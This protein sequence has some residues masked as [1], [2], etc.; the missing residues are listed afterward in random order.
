MSEW[1]RIFDENRV[2]PPPNQTSRLAQGPSQAFRLVFK[3]L[4]GLHLN[5][6]EELRSER[7][8][9][10]VSLFDNSLHRFF[11]RTWKSKPHQA[12]KR[13]QEQPCKV[14]FN[15]VVYFHTS[16]CL[17]SVVA[18]VEL[19]SLSHGTDTSQNAVGQGFGI[20]QLFSEQ[21]QGE[22]RLSLFHGTP[23]ALLHPT[24][25]D[26][27][28]MNAVL[29]AIEGTQLLYSLQPHPALN[30]IMHLLP[31]NI[32]VSGHELIPGVLPPTDSTGDA[33]HRP[34][35]MPAFSCVLEK[36]CVSLSPSI[37][38]FE[39]DLLERLNNDRNN[40]RMGAEVRSVVVQ[41]RRL[42]VGVHNGLGWV[43]G[44]QVMVLEPKSGG[45]GGLKQ[46]STE[47]CSA[48]LMLRG[49]VE[50]R[51]IR[52]PAFSLVFQLEYVFSVPIAGDRKTSSM[53]MQRAVFMQCVRW[54]VWSPFSDPDD[55]HESVHVS[56]QG[57]ALPNPCGV[58]VYT[59]H[60][61]QTDAERSVVK[62]K[63][64]Y[65]TEG[66]TSTTMSK[67]VSQEKPQTKKWQDTS[68]DESKLGLEAS[69]LRTTRGPGLS[70]SQLAVSSHFPTRSHTTGSS[71][72]QQLPAPLAL[73]PMASAHQ[74]S[75]VVH[76]PVGIAHLEVSAMEREGLRDA[77][78]EECD[79]HELTFT[80]VHAPVITLGTHTSGSNRTSSRGFLAHLFSSRF[81]EIRD[82][83]NQVAE[84]L[85]P[86][87]PVNFDPYREET[88]SLQANTLLLQFL[89]FSRVHQAGV[90]MEWPSTVHFTFQ[91]YRFP[92]VTTQRLRLVVSEA[93]SRPD[94]PCILSVTNKDGS[95][96]SGLPGL[97]LQY[98]VDP[99]FLKPGE[100]IWFLR[101]LALHTL[102]IDVWDS[103]SLLLIGSA[104]VPLKHLLRQGRAAVQVIHELEVISTEYLQDASLAREHAGGQRAIPAMS[105]HTVVKGRLFIR[106]GNIGGVVQKNPNP[107][108]LLPPSR[109][110]VI[111]PSQT[112]T[113]FQGGSLSSNAIH[114]LNARNTR[115][116]QRLPDIDGELASLLQSR[117]KEVD[118]AW[119]QSRG[120][121]EEVRQRKIDRMAAVRQHEGNTTYK[122]PSYMRRKDDHSQDLRLIEAY[123]E[124]CKVEGIINMLSQAITTTHTIYATLG[125]AE[126]FEFVL[127]NPFNIPQTVTIECED[128]EL[129]VIVNAEEWRY[130]KDMAKTCTP[131]EVEMFHMKEDSSTPQVYLRPRE[132][133]HIPLK[134]QSFVSGHALLS[135]DSK[136]SNSLHFA[137]PQ[138]SNTVMAKSIKVFFRAADSQP[139]AI[140][141]VRVEPTP[142]IV[143]QTFRFYQPELSFF[144][145][146]IRLPPAEPGTP[147]AGSRLQ[148]RCSDPNVI[149]HV[150]ATPPGEPQDIY[151]KVP[152]APSPQIKTFVI[153]VF[154]D[155]WL[156]SPTQTWQVY[157]HYLQK[158]DISC[159]CGTLSWHSLVLRGTQSIRKVKCYTSHPLELQV[160]P[161]E[162]FALPAMCVQDIRLGVK[163]LHSGSCFRYLNVVD[164]DTRQLV[165]SWLL[166]LTCR[167]PVIS[168]A[169]EIQVPVG[170]GKGSNKKISFTNPYPT[171]R[172]FRLCSDHPDLLQ[173][174][175]EKF[176]IE[177]GASY[178]IGLRFAPS[179]SAGT[180]E[181]LV[182]I[183]DLEDKNE[184]TYCIK[185]VYR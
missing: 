24:L 133:I 44:P 25:R 153:S 5:Q 45:S 87:E 42:H 162:V 27:L 4:D 80:P 46:S 118:G 172:G 41:E 82:D 184:E 105:V 20:L 26:P 30:P 61:Q 138:Q 39:A 107:S 78:E 183:N 175:E 101:Y 141:Q 179:Q 128:P 106:L 150:I 60:T 28:Q 83:F 53:A 185:V 148:V 120:E 135:Q 144:K 66:A 132:S 134:Y 40:M 159:V 23:R 62:F 170:G 8:E 173:F 2:I 86:D 74:L 96:G 93:S 116:A 121:T 33:L 156:A 110:H 81:P 157:M 31:P 91:L 6:A 177:G 95:I 59:A 111:Q 125:T 161:E 19:A 68:Q 166:C 92:H 10:R 36:V 21:A 108:V 109:S 99:A 1:K 167:Q 129:S 12:T 7:Y 168:R 146:A 97:Q 22:G 47:T 115:R 124:R 75:H 17:A 127:K 51:M 117:M 64:M 102:H 34:R 57:G 123:R 176:Q 145:K 158:M 48:V 182:F 18:V 140:C 171:N 143:D 89:A 160:D 126:F 54:G 70:L 55:P 52:H 35:L 98:R 152:G 84:L 50:L 163:A 139:L 63:F 104:A 90:N 151:L 131:L 88:D 147:D 69:P 73:S 16:L 56:L 71:W 3:R 37:Q 112:P 11:G 164:V 67:S 119:L 72:Q 94:Y 13:N 178:N 14:H 165:A 122:T 130:F 38:A 76:P 149:C 142:H 137:Q 29:S 65:N 85:D 58:M 181:I 154:N 15:E 43:D 32:M 169:F 49:N 100:R 79:L 174:K 77:P 113:G 114:N 103:D 9:L 155:P 136:T 180:E